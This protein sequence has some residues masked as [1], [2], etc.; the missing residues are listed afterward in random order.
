MARKQAA[1]PLHDKRQASA[2]EL[3]ESLFDLVRD[4]APC[5]LD[6]AGSAPT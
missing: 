6:E 2:D 4:A 3:A 1:R 5:G